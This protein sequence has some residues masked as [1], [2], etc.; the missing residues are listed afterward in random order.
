MFDLL[1]LDSTSVVKF[2]L[3]GCCCRESCHEENSSWKTYKITATKAVM[4]ESIC[5]ISFIFC[6]SDLGLLFTFSIPR[7]LRR[8]SARPIMMRRKEMQRREEISKAGIQVGERREDVC[9]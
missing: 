7:T 4:A 8:R 2:S 6:S 9:L 3:E 5:S 1:K